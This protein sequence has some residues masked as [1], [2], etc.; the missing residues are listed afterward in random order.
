[1]TQEQ[2]IEYF[3][4]EI[5]RLSNQVVELQDERDA[6]AAHVEAL[7]MAIYNVVHASRNN[8]GN[9]PSLSVYHKAINDAYAAWN[10]APQQHLAEVKA[11]A[12]R[13]GFVAGAQSMKLAFQYGG[14]Y[15]T[16]QK[17]DKYADSIRQGEVK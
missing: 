1:M 11:Q 6:L 8:S 12:G 5:A 4:S 16:E 13:A 9:E 15:S 3:M 17:A 2:R 7:R 10:A 14:S